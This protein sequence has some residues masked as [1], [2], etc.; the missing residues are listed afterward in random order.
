MRSR[1]E[2]TRRALDEIEDAAARY[3]IQQTGLGEAFVEAAR[4]TAKRIAAHPKAFQVVV[5][6]I[7]R[8]NFPRRWPWSLFY[9]VRPDR[10]IVIATLSQRQDLRRLRGR[11]PPEI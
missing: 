6:D 4:E 10:S 7:R 1:V 8:A 11:K 2:F 9:V 5:E 3:E